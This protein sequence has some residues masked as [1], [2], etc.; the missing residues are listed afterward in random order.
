MCYSAACIH[1]LVVSV[2]YQGVYGF[3]T[4]FWLTYG[5]L[6]VEVRDVRHFSS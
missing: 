1:C 2:Q 6:T 3:D 4:A 5:V